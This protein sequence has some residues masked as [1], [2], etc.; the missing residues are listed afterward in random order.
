M[1]ALRC[2]AGLRG[3]HR[4]RAT[5]GSQRRGAAEKLVVCEVSPRDGLQNQPI[6]VTPHDKRRLIRDLYRAGLRYI[7]AT[8]FV[9]PRAVPQMADAEEV[10]PV[11]QT[12]PG[13]RAIALLVNEHGLERAKQAGA[14]AVTV[15]GNCSDSMAKANNN[16]SSAQ[17][18]I[19]TA[20]RVATMA[21]DYG[22]F[23]RVGL[24]SA[25]RCPIDG[26]VDPDKVMDYC[27]QVM[28]AG[29]FDELGL[30]DTLGTADPWEVRKLFTR[31]CQRWP[32]LISA[33][34]HDTQCLAL[35]NTV[36]AIDA[37][38]RIIDASV[39]GLGGCPFCPGAAGNLA[40]EDL[41]MLAHKLGFDTG[42]DLEALW[43][44]A[45]STERMV[46]RETG[47]RTKAWWDQEKRRRQA[48][49]AQS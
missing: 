42:I 18:S 35:A 20:I 44:V 32:G 24:G 48:A 29:Q 14:T 5:S 12:L 30:A 46:G 9:S 7:E 43:E 37:G 10:V 11:T 40:T 13:L 49:A 17:K 39:G 15:I 8:A 25:F 47:G 45:R 27:E 41:V 38:V 16:R 19:D 26:R 6:M 21:K 33:H 2:S 36:G 28:A 23:V 3:A 34:L 31:V 22:M 4:G 1:R